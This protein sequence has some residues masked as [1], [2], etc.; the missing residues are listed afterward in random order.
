MIAKLGNVLDA[1]FDLSIGNIAKLLL[2]LSAGDIQT[3]VSEGI[4]YVMYAIKVSPIYAFNLILKIMSALKK[5]GAPKPIDE[6]KEEN[7]PIKNDLIH[8][9]CME[10]D[11]NFMTALYHYF[12]SDPNCAFESVL[13]DINVK[14][15][16]ENIFHRD[17]DRI[18]LSFPKY[19][20]KVNSSILFG[21]NVDTDEIVFARIKEKIVNA[22]PQSNTTIKTFADLLTPMQRTL[23]D[24]ICNQLQTDY[25]PTP[26]KVIEY[27]KSSTGKNIHTKKI[28][29]EVTMIDMMHEKYNF[30]DKYRAL[31]EL[32]VVVCILY[33]NIGIATIS[34]A[35]STIKSIGKFVFDVDNTYAKDIVDGKS[36][37][38]YA[39]DFAKTV[40]D[41]A[42]KLLIKDETIND[43]FS[44]FK[45]T[46]TALSN[47]KKNGSDVNSKLKFPITIIMQEKADVSVVM[48]EFMTT[49][50]KSY[51]KNNTRIKIYAIKLAE[52]IT[53]E[54]IV[55][56]E[57]EA[58][59]EK[60]DL[61]DKLPT[62]EKST[63]ITSLIAERPKKMIKKATVTKKIVC[64]RLNEIEKDIDTLYLRESDK[65]IL[66]SALDQFK[67]KKHI[68]QSMGFQSKLNVLLY[69]EP[70]TGKST[71]IQAIATFLQRD[72]YYLDLQ[73][74][75]LN[76]DLQLMFDYVNKNVRNGGIIV[77]EDI[78]AMAKIV[79]KRDQSAIKNYSVNDIIS[80]QKNKLSLEY[81]LNIL[82]GTLTVDDSIFIVTTNHLD[83]LD[84]AFYRD[85][86]FDVK[87]ELKL[88]DHFQIN[89][90]YQ[91]MLGREA[92]AHLLDQIPQ[93]K[94]SPATIIYH[95]KTYIFDTTATD[96][97]ILQK[98]LTVDEVTDP[99][100][101]P[102]NKAIVDS[103]LNEAIVRS[104]C[105]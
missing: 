47:A 24:S 8:D 69:G 25:G 53:T 12:T 20:V 5:R 96:E 86:R 85:G 49:I 55:N 64:D 88:C 37:D 26:K 42:K 15:L 77:I 84:P 60:K 62:T 105:S 52:D 10:I 46:R 72:I 81:F 31:I 11:M 2:I 21:L 104:F 80:D 82:Q 71:T 59:K 41:C 13:T 1:G 40:N 83:H 61:V 38:S 92:P 6:S 97:I 34:D 76:E 44:P 3:M 66:M 102:E 87:I 19:T 98:F 43:A 95:I 58:W 27:I 89:T 56:E 91:K 30:D 18:A 100:I 29:S 51:K 79:L 90:I 36:I 28:F 14:N 17:Y 22:N 103:D 73:K 70:G 99:V 63:E 68:L 57:Y 7:I 94:F 32:E 93:N 67:N 45:E 50:Y 16:K 74:A 23:V 65:N 9:V 54:D 78:D 4:S 39:N 33:K 75:L 35:G 48:N 101:V